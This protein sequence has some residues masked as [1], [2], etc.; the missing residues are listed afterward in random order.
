MTFRDLQ[1]TIFGVARQDVKR[2]K[3]YLFA[4]RNFENKYLKFA[5]KINQAFWQLILRNPPNQESNR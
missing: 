4:L 1:L 2:G 5:K 3:Y